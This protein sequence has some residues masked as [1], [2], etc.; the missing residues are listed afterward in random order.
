MMLWLGQMDFL[1]SSSRIINY[2]QELVFSI[3]TRS[4]GETPN[5]EENKKKETD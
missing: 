2:S 4:F 3:L 1:M 5:R